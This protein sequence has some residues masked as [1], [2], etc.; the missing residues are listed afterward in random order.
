MIQGEEDKK[1]MS[2][3]RVEVYEVRSV[4]DDILFSKKRGIFLFNVGQSR[5]D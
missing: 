1:D 3:V 5:L 4:M 2:E